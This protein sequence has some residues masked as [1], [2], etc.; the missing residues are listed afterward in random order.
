MIVLVTGSMKVVK[1]LSLAQLLVLKAGTSCSPQV[2]CTHLLCAADYQS[3]TGPPRS[4][5]AST[6]PSLTTTLE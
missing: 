6:A 4:M 1:V 5:T 2:A 3:G